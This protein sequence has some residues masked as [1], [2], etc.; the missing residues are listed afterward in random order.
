M[1][2]EQNCWLLQGQAPDKMLMLRKNAIPSVGRCWYTKLMSW[3]QNIKTA[4]HHAQP[5]TRAA[6][7]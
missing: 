4:S 7:P 5:P 1:T 6:T 3:A 2:V